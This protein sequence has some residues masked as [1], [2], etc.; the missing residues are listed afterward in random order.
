FTRQLQD[1][2]RKSGLKAGE[3]VEVRYS[4][5]DEL[6]AAIEQGRDSIAAQCFAVSLERAEPQSELPTGYVG[7]SELKVPPHAISV[8][9]RRSSSVGQ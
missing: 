2:R 9:L 4:T 6:A 8:V 3:P 7:W 1:L 5:D